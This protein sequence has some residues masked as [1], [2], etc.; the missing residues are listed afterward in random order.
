[1]NIFTKTKQLALFLTLASA[2]PALSQ[3]QPEIELPDLGDSSSGTISLAQEYQL[4]RIWLKSFRSRV[5]IVSDPLLQDYVE[6]FTYKLATYSE[7]DDRRLDLI[8]V[9]NRTINAFAVPGGV[10][11][12]HSGLILQAETEA[13][14]ASV[15]SHELAHLSQRHFAR[16]V[17]A[18]KRNAI[19]NMA[20]LLAG[21][22]LAATAGGD[23]GMAAI[24]ATQAASL[25]NQLR[26]SRLNEQEADRAGMQTMA[27]AN[28]D[29]N[30]AAAMFEVMQ[31]TYRYASNRPPEFLL[32]HP[33]TES[34]ISDARNR[35]RQ[36]PKKMY[37]DN[38]IYHLMQARVA[39]SFITNPKEAVKQF[40]SKLADSRYHPDANQY[41]LVLA[42]TANGEFEEAQQRL[43]LLLKTAPHEISYVVAQAE[44]DMAAGKLQEAISI[45]SEN[46][47]LTPGN[48]PL[49][50]TMAKALLAANQAHKAEALLLTHSRR[51]PN[52]PS[53]W[54]LLAETH[55]LAGNIVGVHRA[56]AE[57]FILNGAL[58][59][60]AKQLNYALPL[61]SQDNLTTAKIQE[62]IIQI[63]KM[64][65][66]MRNL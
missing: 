34:R 35:A 65:A 24:A 64:E 55:G 15:M 10:I 58:D 59:M 52:D 9:N 60:A 19:P 41:G 16:G 29:P 62:R 39:L 2:I 13:Q 6:E 22:I 50:M 49:T 25:Q 1:M 18:Q 56:R 38:P 26:Y 51:K 54:Y 53:V 33:I 31:R 45:L 63:K 57:Y 11:G 8:V 37:S 7:L 46:L 12:I 48:H 47:D 43:N 32:T 27:R 36:Y 3:T 14:F 20:G 5:D 30:G 21:I 44:L 17:E 66:Q 42:L 23:S 40:R 4:G 61:V 28:M